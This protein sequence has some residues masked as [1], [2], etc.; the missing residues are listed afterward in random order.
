[1]E[2][3]IVSDKKETATNAVSTLL[4]KMAN[5]DS[6]NVAEISKELRKWYRVLNRESRFHQ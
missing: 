6:A 5:A 3:K 2:I 1:M 4:F